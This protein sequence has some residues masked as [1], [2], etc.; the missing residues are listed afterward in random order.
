MSLCD[1][2]RV[3]TLRCRIT[4]KT[5]KARCCAENDGRGRSRFDMQSVMIGIDAAIFGPNSKPSIEACAGFAV[6]NRIAGLIVIEVDIDGALPLITMRSP[7]G[8]F[9]AGADSIAWP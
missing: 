2:G 4:V 8:R 6:T 3:D 5:I 1:W 9:D 7:L